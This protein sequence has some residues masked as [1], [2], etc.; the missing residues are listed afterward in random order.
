MRSE[1]QA[2]RS[3]SGVSDVT[4]GAAF[5]KALG[6]HAFITGEIAENAPQFL[7]TIY[8]SDAYKTIETK[9]EAA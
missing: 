1:T 3:G 8:V 4:L 6:A 2:D 5:A 9:A 7:M